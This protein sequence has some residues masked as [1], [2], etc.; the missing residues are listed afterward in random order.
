MC[1][2]ARLQDR[3]DFEEEIAGLFIEP[4]ALP[5]GVDDFRDEIRWLVN[6]VHAAFKML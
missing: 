5:R 1:Y 6:Y 3:R 2:H 4:L